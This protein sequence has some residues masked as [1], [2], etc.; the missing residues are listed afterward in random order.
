MSSESLHHG[1][2][3]DIVP[4]FCAQM[5]YETMRARGGR[6]TLYPYLGMDH[7]QPV[8]RYVTRSLTDFAKIR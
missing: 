8:N 2:H 6:V 4:F 5:A 3:D 1:T 7:Y